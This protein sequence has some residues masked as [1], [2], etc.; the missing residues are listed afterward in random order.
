MNLIVISN[1]ITK[2]EQIE[3]KEYAAAMPVTE[4][5]NEHIRAV[6]DQIKGRSILCDLTKTD[7]SKG[8]SA[9]QGDA[10]EIKEVPALFHNI[11]CRIAEK[12]KI[13]ADHAFVQCIASGDG[14]RVAP[15]YDAAAPGYVTYKCNVAIDGPAKDLVF[16]AGRP[17]E[18]QP[19]DLYCFEANLYKHWAEVAT[20]RTLLS[21]GFMLPLQDLGWSKDDARVRMSDRIWSRF[22]RPV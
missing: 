7:I 6:N 13:C 4:I 5:A 3:L 10:T 20:A 1:F 21:Y 8:V 18:V 15:H 17:V 9:F 14:G 12:L 11:G 22:S 16:I 2:K 19:G